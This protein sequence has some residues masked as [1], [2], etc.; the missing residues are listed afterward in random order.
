MRVSKFIFSLIF[1][2]SFA[3]LYVYQQSEIFRMA[4]T[5]Q[6][7]AVL[8]QDLLDKNTLLRYNIESSASLVRIGNK[9]SSMSDYEMPGVYQLV[10]APESAQGKRMARYIPK[11]QNLLAQI[12]SVKTEAQAKTINP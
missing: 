4:Y 3:L 11:K 7:K 12:F 6:K 1:T 5:A 9:I 8:F 2:T 10:R